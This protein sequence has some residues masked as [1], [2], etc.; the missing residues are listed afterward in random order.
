[1][2]TYT[3]P[4]S[5]PSYFAS[6]HTITRLSRTHW[7]ITSPSLTSPLD[8]PS[9]TAAKAYASTQ[10]FTAPEPINAEP[11]PVETAEPEQAQFVELTTEQHIKALVTVA[12]TLPDPLGVIA[13]EI[14]NLDGVA[15][16]G[17]LL[18]VK[19]EAGSVAVDNIRAHIMGL[20]PTLDRI[21]S[22]YG[23]DTKGV[24]VKG[25]YRMGALI[26]DLVERKA[27]GALRWVGQSMTC[28]AD[29][30]VGRLALECEMMKGCNGGWMRAQDEAQAA[31]DGGFER[32]VREAKEGKSLGDRWSHVWGL[33]SGAWGERAREDVGEMLKGEGGDYTSALL[34]P[35]PEHRLPLSE[36]RALVV[37]WIEDVRPDGSVWGKATVWLDDA[38]G[39]SLLANWTPHSGFGWRS[40]SVQ[41]VDL[42]ALDRLLEVVNGEGLAVAV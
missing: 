6:T 7:Q 38:S 26:D 36:G 20:G 37:S 32:A 10:T 3:H 30:W 42:V 23:V 34:L 28:G 25:G 5:S 22:V 39:L 41:G 4:T 21:A 8:F 24:D 18:S 40:P 2:H 27:M 31:M 14:A 16:V 13:Q 9:Y 1:M 15:I 19:T 11:S 29:S 12:Q 17:A 35:E 33:V